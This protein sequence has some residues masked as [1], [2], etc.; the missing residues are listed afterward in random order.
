MFVLPYRPFRVLV[1]AVSRLKR[2]SLAESIAAVSRL[3][4]RSRVLV[5]ADYF[6]WHHCIEFWSLLCIS[7]KR[8]W[9]VDLCWSVLNCR[10]LLPWKFW[11][12]ICFLCCP[13]AVKTLPAVSSGTPL[14]WQFIWSYLFV[15][16][17]TFLIPYCKKSHCDCWA[18]FNYAVVTI[19]ARTIDT[20]STLK[21]LTNL[22][23]LLFISKK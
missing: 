21:Y 2:H 10:S 17:S 11:L 18:N 13:G 15:Q 9:S 23:F 14:L 20:N 8:T 4:H 7:F 16:V 12:Q 3:Q 22:L 19:V 6:P 1:P 5:T